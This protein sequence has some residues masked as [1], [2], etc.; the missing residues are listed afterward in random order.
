VFEAFC[1]EKL[2]PLTLRGALGFVCIYHGFVKI[3]A[4]GGT[5]WSPGLAVGW[6]LLIAWSELGAG[7]AILLGIRCRLAVAVMLT[8]TAGTWLWWKGWNLF[9]LPLAVLEPFLVL[10]LAGIALLFLGAGELSLDGRGGARGLRF[11]RKS[12]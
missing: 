2:A 5:A 9:T 11:A 10:L 7:V 6:Q 8:V 4:A 3:M 1:K 12:A